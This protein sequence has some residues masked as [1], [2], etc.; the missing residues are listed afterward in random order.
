MTSRERVKAAMHY[1]PVDKV[2]VQFYYSP[3]GY[4]EHGEKLNDL[5]RTLP[6]DFEP[7]RQ[8]AI[9]GPAPEDYDA[10]GVYHAFRQDEWG[11]LWEYR[12]FGITGIP[13]KYPIPSL[14]HI[15]QYPF[16]PTPSWSQ[17]E[18]ETLLAR[19]KEKQREF[20]ALFP[21][22]TLLERLQQILPDEE[23]YCGLELDDPSLNRLADKVC[24]Y[25]AQFVQRAIE[26]GADGIS[27]GDDYGSE[28][29]MLMSPRTWRRFFKPRLKELFQPAVKAGLDIHFHSCGQISPIL[30][31]FR[32]IGI[33]SIWPQLPAYNMQE[34]AEKCR[35]L[36]L[37]VA[38]HT[39]R[40]NT[41]T[42]GT[43]QEVQELVK[44]EYEV[45]QMQ[46]GGSWFYIEADNGFP[47]EN[48]AALIETIR[49]L[50]GE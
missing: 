24:A 15:D 48:I 46:N 2:P 1:Q 13:K 27:F 22:G 25:N 45:F 19:T 14:E 40:A 34:L 28:R 3:V 41:M 47:F 17:E 38:I 11:T 4:Y 26:A 35:S 30:E 16:P 23:F 8:M 21:A 33:T 37:A 50:R 43:P 42:Y 18:K 36:G 32:E 10:D 12:I 7:F 6:G 39:D 9:C 20:Y 29:S 44:R 31:D 5:Y 49:K